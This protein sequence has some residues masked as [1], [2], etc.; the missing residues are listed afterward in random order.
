M[1]FNRKEFFDG[2]RSFL[3]QHDKQLSRSRTA[4]VEFLLDNFESDRK[5]S[6]VRF[7]AYALATIFIETAY[8]FE[9][10]Q[11]YGT[12]NYFERRYGP[13]TAVGK[14]LGND[15]AGE[16]AKYSGKGFVQL[17]GESNYEK[18]ETKLRQ[19]Y[20]DLLKDFQNRTGKE[21][22]LTDYA[23]QAKEPDLAFAI[24]TVGMFEGVYTG[25][26]FSDYINKQ[27]TDYRNARRIINGLDRAAEIAAIARQFEKILKNSL[28]KDSTATKKDVITSENLTVEPSTIPVDVP[29]IEN[30]PSAETIPV[31]QTPEP[32]P[33]EVPQAR[34]EPES[35]SEI[36]KIK[37]EMKV[38]AKSQIKARFVALPGMIL[39]ALSALWERIVAGETNLVFWLVG[40]VVVILV[41][42]IGFN[43]WQDANE[44]KTALEKERGDRELKLQ[45]ENQAFQITLK[46]ME[47]AMR[48]DLN[49]IVVVPNP[50]TNSDSEEEK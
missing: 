12:Y 47:S 30:Q 13:Q 10:I 36:N 39:A 26:K 38:E 5:W 45:R 43:K 28:E 35:E 4:A 3:A 14:R 31:A 24:M 6:D 41:A 29:P 20:A 23:D 46:Q 22:D 8:T 7:I 49:T 17:T 9:P 50:I 33:I 11:E 44:K 37:D 34:P 16:G 48:K 15:A 2:F 21:F 32:P 18:L 1:Q 25:K 27:K 40:A 19:Q 42:Y